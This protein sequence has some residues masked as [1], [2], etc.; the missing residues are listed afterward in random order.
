MF[1]RFANGAFMEA[2]TFE[3]AQEKMIEQIKN[4]KENPKSWS[5]CT[6]LGFDHY[7]DCPQHWSN[8]E[9]GEIPF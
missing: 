3:E 7:S 5:K 6:C 4:E 2:N 1:Y 8:R 9:D